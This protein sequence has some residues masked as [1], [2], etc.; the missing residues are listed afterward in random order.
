MDAAANFFV[1]KSSTNLV[2]CCHISY[3]NKLFFCKLYICTANS[4][5]RYPKDHQFPSNIEGG[6]VLHIRNSFESSLQS[7][8]YINL[9]NAEV[10]KTFISLLRYLCLSLAW[11]LS[12]VLTLLVI[13][14]L[15]QIF[16]VFPLFDSSVNTY[17]KRVLASTL[18]MPPIV[19]KISLVVLH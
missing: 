19:P 17:C 18:F 1:L 14:N 9:I 8:I 12:Y 11:I 13:D 10:T 15:R 16:L 3:P 6:G 4:E 5:G 7:I 2:V